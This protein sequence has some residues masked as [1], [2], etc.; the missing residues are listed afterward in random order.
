M[1]TNEEL[2]Q[3]KPEDQVVYL[4]SLNNPNLEGA[5]K[6]VR[7]KGLEN[8]IADIAARAIQRITDDRPAYYVR[9]KKPGVYLRPSDQIRRFAEKFGVKIPEK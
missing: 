7:E 8:R 6:V 1:E 2:D 9:E 5:E 4:L 3:Q